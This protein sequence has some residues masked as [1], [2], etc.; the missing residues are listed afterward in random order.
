MVDASEGPLHIFLSTA[1]SVG[2]KQKER[3]EH[4]IKVFLASA[5]SK[6]LETNWKAENTVGYRDQ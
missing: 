2:E 1:D 4:M 5:L 3:T 6:T